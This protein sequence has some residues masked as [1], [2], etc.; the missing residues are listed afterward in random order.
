MYIHFTG[1]QGTGKT[2]LLNQLTEESIKFDSDIDFKIITNVVR[3]LVGREGVQINKRGNSASQNLIFNEYLKIFNGID[4]HIDWVSDRSLIDVV[5]YTKYLYEH[6]KASR[7]CYESQ[8][9]LLELWY[10]ENLRAKDT[11]F[12]YF[13]IE[14]EVVNDGVRSLDED[15]RKEIDKNIKDIL[16]EINANYYIMEGTQ[17]ER[18]EMMKN[19]IWLNK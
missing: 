5:A 13:P 3:N 10:E 17:D 9:Q 12:V 7:K 6:K 1:A 16:T 11:I 18:L 15:Y 2:T 14:F 19:I 8:L 4:P